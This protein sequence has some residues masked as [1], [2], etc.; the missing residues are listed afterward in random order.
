VCALSIHASR[1]RRPGAP[2]TVEPPITTEQGTVVGLQVF[3]VRDGESMIVAVME[4]GDFLDLRGVRPKEKQDF[5]RLHVLCHALMPVELTPEQWQQ[6]FR[7]EWESIQS[8]A[9]PYPTD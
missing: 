5:L 8:S 3:R 1:T 2:V 7:Q 6:M 9:D 4:S